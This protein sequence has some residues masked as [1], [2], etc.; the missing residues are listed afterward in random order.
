MRLDFPAQEEFINSLSELTNY[1]T[2]NDKTSLARFAPELVLIET[3][4]HSPGHTSF[5]FPDEKILFSGDMG[6]DRFG[7]W[8]GWADCSIPDIVES[9]LRLDGLD[10]ELVLTSHGGVLK[11]DIQK[12]WATCLK[13]LVHREEKI[14]QQL[15][16]GQTKEE[17]ISKGVFFSN[18]E[19]VKPPM[20]QFLDM[21]DRSM[22]DHHKALIHSGGLL[23]L[24][25]EINSFVKPIS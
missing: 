11:K 24:F 21:W 5:Y 3:P 19:K 10:V 2:Y 7:P 1:E 6:L 8:Y 23:N 13:Q 14:V 16:A 9:I 20:K 12:A 4:G 25:P 22:Y 15:E 17:I 18:K